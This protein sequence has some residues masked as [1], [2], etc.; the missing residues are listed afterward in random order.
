MIELKNIIIIKVPNL[1][2]AI[3]GKLY[4]KKRFLSKSNAMSYEFVLKKDRKKKKE[5][6]NQSIKKKIKIATIS[7][8]QRENFF[9]RLKQQLFGF[10][11]L[12]IFKI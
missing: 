4:F 5:L 7:T 1:Q 9:K 8:L 2:R 12:K 10:M 3:N 6:L 11:I